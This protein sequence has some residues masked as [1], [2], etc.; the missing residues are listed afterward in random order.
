MATTCVFFDENG[1]SA[2][3][4]PKSDTCLSNAARETETLLRVLISDEEI[5][6]E[7]ADA[8]RFSERIRRQP[9]SRRL[10]ETIV[11]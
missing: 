6:A 3:Q 5:A 4:Q 11:E 9:M 2:G 8:D 1:V 10:L 7:F